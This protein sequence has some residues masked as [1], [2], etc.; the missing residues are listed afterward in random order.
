MSICIKIGFPSKGYPYDCS[1]HAWINVRIWNV[2]PWTVD[3]HSLDT[4][5][6]IVFAL[7]G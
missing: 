2:Y 7:T 1:R 3:V 6:V 5:K 4:K